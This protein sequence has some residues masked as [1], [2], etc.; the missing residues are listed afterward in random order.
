MSSLKIT[1]DY[2]SLRRQFST[3]ENTKEE[4]RIIEYQAVSGRIVDGFSALLI[5]SSL[6]SQMEANPS[7][8][9]LL[10]PYSAA[11]DRIILPRLIEL[12]ECCGGY[13]YLQVSGH[14]ALIERSLY[15]TADTFETNIPSN[16]EFFKLLKFNINPKSKKLYEQ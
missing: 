15:S 4:R 1:V 8:A 6:R 12:R 2:T 16:S 11:I 10:Q 3:Q 5:L 7:L 14:P 9:N 13:G